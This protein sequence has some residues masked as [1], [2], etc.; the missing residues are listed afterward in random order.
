MV[1]FNLNICESESE[2]KSVSGRIFV[3]LVFG[4]LLFSDFG[5]QTCYLGGDAFQRGRYWGCRYGP[6]FKLSL[7]KH[8][9]L[10]IYRY[11]DFHKASFKELLDYINNLTLQSCFYEVFKLLL[12]NATIAISSSSV[13]R[14]FHA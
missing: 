5:T 13:E 1:L 14:S 6:L 11:P 10:F 4:E 3:C 8:Q 2:S 12:L 7:L 9:L